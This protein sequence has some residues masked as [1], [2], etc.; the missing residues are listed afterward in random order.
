MKRSSAKSAP[1]RPKQPSLREYASNVGTRRPGRVCW[2]CQIPERKQVDS[3]RRAFEAR[4]SEPI[5]IP[6]IVEWLRLR[7]HEDATEDRVVGHFRRGHH[8]K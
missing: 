4:V 1:G 3:E 6:R 7:G 5:S 2:L 8:R